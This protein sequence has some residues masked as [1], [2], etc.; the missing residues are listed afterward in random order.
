MAG[1]I[2]IKRG[3]TAQWADS[4]TNDI[5]LAP[6]QPG[7][8]YCTDGKTKLKIGPHTEDGSSTEWAEINY[9]SAEGAEMIK[10]STTGKNY[11]ISDCAEETIVS[12]TA[13]GE[14]VQD[15]APTPDSPVEI[16]SVENPTITIAGKNLLDLHDR[17]DAKPTGNWPIS[18]YDTGNVIYRGF[19]YSGYYQLS[20][21]SKSDVTVDGNTVT[22]T[23]KANGYGIGYVVRCYPNTN[24]YFSGTLSCD[25][26]CAIFIDTDG[27]KISDTFF[28]KFTTPQNARYVILSFSNNNTT[29]TYTITNPQ[30]EI[31]SAATS[32]EPYNGE[33]TV[34]IPYTFRGL[35]NTNGDWAARDELRVGDGR[36][37]IVRNCY[38]FL[39][40]ETGANVFYLN[41]TANVMGYVVN[42]T[43]QAVIPKMKSQ[44]RVCGMC[45][46]FESITNNRWAGQIEGQGIVFGGNNQAIYLLNLIQELPTKDDFIQYCTANPFEIIY[47]RDTPEIEDITDTEAGQALLA[48]KTN[49]PT[50]TIISDI[51]C[52]IEYLTVDSIVDQKYNPNSVYPQS[53]KAVAEAIQTAIGNGSSVYVGQIEQ[54][55]ENKYENYSTQVNNGILPETVKVNDIYIDTLEGFIWK[56]NSVST[57]GIFMYCFGKVGNNCLFGSTGIPPQPYA[58]YAEGQLYFDTSTNKLYIRSTNSWEEVSG[59]TENATKLNWKDATLIFDKNDGSEVYQGSIK[60][61]EDSNFIYVN[62][63]IMINNLSIQRASSAKLDIDMTGIYSIISANNLTYNIRDGVNYETFFANTMDIS[64]SKILGIHFTDINNNIDFTGKELSIYGTY[65]FKK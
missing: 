26:F 19:A 62:F 24:Y 5:T 45:S 53:G 13:Y 65:L 17:T 46:R 11:T 1:K 58:M 51:D 44:N 33:Q 56:V 21:G 55:S 10:T 7:V 27:N 57:D 48:L 63:D 36:V 2:K 20:E 29:G 54:L 41:D 32:Y 43:T 28:R 38:S 40:D 49:S 64:P 50:T 15:G 4:S 23:Q 18:K 3:T 61:A 30:L 6:G 16:V 14:S 22:F 60:Y 8:E 9:I 47:W 52:N 37:E 25:V 34:T 12:L 42:T 31:G 39:V 35:K 59:S